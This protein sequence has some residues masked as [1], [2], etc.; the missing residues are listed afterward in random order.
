MKQRQNLLIQKKS[1][2]NGTDATATEYQTQKNLQTHVS[3]IYI[4]ILCIVAFTSPLLHVVFD[5]KGMEG[6]LGYKYMSSFLFA[7]GNRLSAISVALLFIFASQQV[8]NE[9]RTT[10]K[11]A[12][13]TALFIA[14]FFAVQILIPKHLLLKWS[15]IKDLPQSAYYITMIIGGIASVF[16]LFYFQ[17]AVIY[18]EIRLRRII[19]VLMDSLYTGLEEKQLINPW[20]TK[21]FKNHRIEVTNK[22]VDYEQGRL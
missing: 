8:Q 20:R 4:I 18:S 5:V 17:K 2:Q 15:G 3:S 1:A 7:A 11:I 12:S 10:L 6:Y 22:V 9:Y 14:S 13:Y 16:V 19:N 21:E